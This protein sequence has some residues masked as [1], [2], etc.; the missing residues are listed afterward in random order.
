MKKMRLIRR[1]KE[2]GIIT[3]EA[4]FKTLDTKELWLTIVAVDHDQIGQKR[5]QYK[6]EVLKQVQFQRIVSIVSVYL[7]NKV[8]IEF[9]KCFKD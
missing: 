2:E 5:S 8:L 7:N 3:I 1:R 4:L 6:A 9:S